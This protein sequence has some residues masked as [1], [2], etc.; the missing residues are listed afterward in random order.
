MPFEEIPHSA[1]W[2]LRVWAEDLNQLF[3][4]SA[5]GMYHLSGTRWEE[6]SR[7][8]HNFSVSS[9]DA[10]SLLVAFLSELVFLAEQKRLAFDG[11]TLFISSEYNHKMR[12]S[13]NMTGGHIESME[14]AIKAVTFH[15]LQI[16]Q[17]EPGVEV[18]IVFDV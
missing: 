8:E 15:N 1:D 3:I 13:A 4:D 18:E 12:L 2:C 17:T 7:I 14:K 6:K 10:E 9:P 11:Y 16:Q 5:R